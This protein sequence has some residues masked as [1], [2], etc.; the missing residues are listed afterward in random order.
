MSTIH[1]NFKQFGALLSISTILGMNVVA[2]KALAQQAPSILFGPAT[3]S[4]GGCTIDTQTS[5]NDG[6]TLSI[7]LNNMSAING[8]RQRCILRVE[9]NIPS[10]FRA[11]ELQVQYQGDTVVNSGSKGTS[12][13]RSFSILGA[14]GILTTTPISTSFTSDTVI[15][16]VDRYSLLSASC[17]G[18][19]VVSM[20]LI[21]RSS[22]GSEIVLDTGDINAGNVRFSFPIIRC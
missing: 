21:A 22:V 8:Q 15:N 16:E 5:L 10:G 3:A 18:Q 9:A 11:Q 1:M 12:F 20:N 17:G 4:G 13:S 2:S 19:G 14:L 7:V 6:R